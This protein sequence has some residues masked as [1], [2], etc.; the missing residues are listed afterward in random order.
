[1]NA[2]LRSL[3]VAAISAMAVT[4]P[5]A[6]HAVEVYGKAILAVENI[7][8]ETNTE[9]FWQVASYDSRLGVRG[10]L[11][12]DI[13]GL[14]AIYNIEWQIDMADRSTTNEATSSNNH[15][16]S[17]N[18]WVGLKGGFGEAVAGRNDTP[19]KRAQGKVDLFND[20]DADIKFLMFG[21]EVRSNN[22]FQYSSP[23]IADAFTV[24]IMARPGEQTT[25]EGTPPPLPEI[26]NGLADATSVSLTYASGPLYLS[27]A[28]DS[29]IDGLD[30]DTTRIVAQWTADNYGIGVLHQTA[31]LSGPILLANPLAET[32]DEEVTF[33]SAYYNVTAMTRLK[34]QSGTLS[35]YG[36]IIEADGD[37]TTFG[38]DFALS[39]KTILG[40]LVASR[41]GGDGSNMY[42]VDPDGE[43]EIRS[44]D[45]I[46]IN[47]EHNFE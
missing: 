41:E 47:L 30:T 27:L 37:A 15:I 28:A 45:T 44:R 36:S 20:R 21:G 31:D 11:D 43:L 25:A 35:N 23:K 32:D 46:G 33:F 42:V 34:V 26:N 13:E 17:R 14:K 5:V 2:H 22:T 4:T 7:D 6:S 40:I 8:Q 3:V 16:S 24:S 39:K 18:Q 10:D 12:T 29:D 1:M 9:D 38:V 19:L